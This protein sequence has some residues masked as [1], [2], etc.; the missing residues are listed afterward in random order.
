MRAALFHEFQ[1]SIDVETV[2]DPSPPAD[3]VV[4]KVMANGVCRSDWHAWMGHDPDIKSLPHVPGHECAGIIEAVG[5]E[6]RN[7]KPGMRAIIPVVSGCGHCGYCL[8][9]QHQVCPDQ[10]QPGFSG[11]G[12]FAEYVAVPYADANLVP[13]PEEISFEVGGSLGCRFT[14]AFRVVAQQADVKPGQWIAIHACGGVGLSAIVIAEAMGANVIAIDIDD[15]KLALAK[16]AGAIHT[17]NGM[18]IND[19]PEAI[20]DLSGGGT[21]VS[22]D[23][24]GSPLTCRNSILSLRRQ[25]RHIQVGLLLGG[26]NNPPLPMDRVVAH[27]LEIIGSHAMAGHTFPDMMAMVTSGKVKPEKLIKHRVTLAEGAKVLEKLGEFPETGVTMI[28][29][30]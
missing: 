17:I 14:T 12:S 5:P 3:G 23:A 6:V 25:G 16:E 11:W 15:D 22:V 9:G 28:T 24:L 1:G 27:E 29:E 26:E 21:H 20:M 18:K 13:L 2:A 10:Y 4:M 8:D 19:V 30:F 7:W